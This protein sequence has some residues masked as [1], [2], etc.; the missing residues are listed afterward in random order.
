M[1]LMVD[2]FDP[3]SGLKVISNKN[4]R[5]L[6]ILCDVCHAGYSALQANLSLYKFYAQRV[7]ATASWPRV[8][9]TFYFFL[10][11]LFLRSSQDRTLGVTKKF[12]RFGV[13]SCS[14]LT[15]DA[16]R[17]PS[18]AACSSNR[19]IDISFSGATLALVVI[20]E[21]ITDT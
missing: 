16:M 8:L 9:Q 11:G 13:C 21:L 18:T 10:E 5:F 7:Q 3:Q 14:S 2:M 1:Q 17:A 20:H 4:H 15:A 12:V 19:V 6:Q